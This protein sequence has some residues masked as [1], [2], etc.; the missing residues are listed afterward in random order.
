MPTRAAGIILQGLSRKQEPILSSR[1]GKSESLL[2]AGALCGALLAASGLL[3]PAS[4][5]PGGAAVAVI[6]GEV[7]SKTEYLTHLNL[8]S[9]DK[10]QALTEADYRRVLDRIIEELLMIERGLQL[11]LLQSDSTVRK[12]MV[13]AMM[14]TVLGDTAM[15]QPK[16]QVLEEFYAANLAYFTTP[17]RL[18]VQRMVFRGS[19]A[20]Q[21]ADAA[22]LALTAG[23][24]WERIAEQHAD[25]GLL[26]L[27]GNLLPV[28]KLR[29]YLG[30]S[31]TEASVSLPVGGHSPAL[32][33][34]AG[35]TIL[36]LLERQT[37]APPPLVDIRERV[38]REYL[39]RAGDTALRGY[40][41]Q[42]RRQADITIDEQFIA[43]LPQ[44]SVQ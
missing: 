21:R 12:A 33:E 6:N 16:E 27:P 20:Q 24:D 34:Q 30:P 40:L 23:A 29:G 28:N 15:E 19:D 2:L 22:Y 43:G 31:L 32:R 39:R 8:L 42:L 37:P 25:P 1:F 10:R 9:R 38:S 14:E 7:I 17:T 26:A 18:R 3:E 44:L 4:V 13:N 11:G 35:Y 41:E 36:K 5:Q